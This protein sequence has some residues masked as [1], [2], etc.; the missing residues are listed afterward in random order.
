MQTQGIPMGEKASSEIANL[1]CYAMESQM[2]SNV[3]AEYGYSVAQKFSKVVRYIDDMLGCGEMYWNRLP[4]KMEH[5]ETTQS[6]GTVQFL[7]MKITKLET[8][9]LLEQQP[10]GLGWTWRPQKYL[11]VSSAHRHFTKRSVLKS[12]HMRAGKSQARGKRSRI[13][14]YNARK[15]YCVDDTPGRCFSGIGSHIFMS[16]LDSSARRKEHWPSGLICGW[17]YT[18]KKHPQRLIRITHK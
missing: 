10:K 11:D 5:R 2:V 18:S 6:D 3:I 12:L 16:I 14:S 9:L 17:M 13:P 15:A 1:Y 4:Y 7:G 8:T